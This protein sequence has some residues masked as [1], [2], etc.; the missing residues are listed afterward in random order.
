MP[1]MSV[2]LINMQFI[3]SFPQKKKKDFLALNFRLLFA[4]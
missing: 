2:A 4:L 3:L 1:S